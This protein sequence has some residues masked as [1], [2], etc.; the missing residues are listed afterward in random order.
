MALL[1]EMP[2][3]IKHVP[4]KGKDERKMRKEGEMGKKIR[5]GRDLSKPRALRTPGSQDQTPSPN[6]SNR[7]IIVMAIITS[8]ICLLLF[9][10]PIHHLTVVSHMSCSFP[11]LGLYV[12]NNSNS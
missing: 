8:E 9:A 7:V 4:H 11:S 1:S 3:R 2:K 12:L 5:I 10:K 6:D